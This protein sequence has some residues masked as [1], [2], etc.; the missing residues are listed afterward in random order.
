MRKIT[1]KEDPELTAVGKQGVPTRITVTLDDGRRV[2]RQVND[3]PGF[4]GRP[5]LRADIERK[6]RGN[7]G[8]RLPE[9]RVT[10]VLKELWD[11]DVATDIAK[12]MGRLSLDV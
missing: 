3:I 10:S 7:V 11:L 6:F 1:V 5:M 8:K 4:P 9:E 12:L 2:V